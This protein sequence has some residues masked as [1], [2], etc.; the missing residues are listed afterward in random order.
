[1]KSETWHEEY[2]C[3]FFHKN[4]QCKFMSNAGE[5][6]AL[7]FHYNLLFPAQKAAKDKLLRRLHVEFEINTFYREP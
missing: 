5:L 2:M 7:R 3:S 4:N 1:M 6:R